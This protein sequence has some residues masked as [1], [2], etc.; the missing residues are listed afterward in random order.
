M[1]I[2]QNNNILV[3]HLMDDKPLENK[4]FPLRLVGSD[5]QKNEM[6]GQIVKITLR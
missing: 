5:L 4:Y 3:F 6:V 2:K 1:R